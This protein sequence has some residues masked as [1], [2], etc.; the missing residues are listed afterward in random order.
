MS[1]TA[2]MSSLRIQSFEHPQ[3]CRVWL[4]VDE[5]TRDAL[6]LDPH[7]DLIA[8][9]GDTVERDRL[10]LR[11]IVDSHTHAD[12]PSGAAALQDRIGGTRVAHK[13]G[14][15]EGVE[16]HPDDGDNLELGTQVVQ[17]RHAPGHTPD[18]LVLL[19]DGHLFAG[20]TL[21]IGGV[22][23]A[24]FL[25]GD[26]G[27]LFDTLRRII[28]PLPGSTV[29][30]PGHDY[31]NRA[32]STLEVERQSNP[33][34]RMTDRAEFIKHLTANPPPIPA[35]MDLLLKWNREG[36]EFPRDVPPPEFAKFVNEGGASSVID[37]RTG[38][39]WR[40]SHIDGSEHIPMGQLAESVERIRQIPAPRML[41]C[42]SDQRARSAQNQLEELGVRGLVVAT[43][44]I[45]AFEAGGGTATKSRDVMSLERQVRLFAGTLVV[46]GVAFGVLVHPWFLAISAFAGCGLIFAGLTDHCGA[47]LLLAKMPWN[48]GGGNSAMREPVAACAASAPP[49]ACAA[50][51]PPASC[52]ASAP[53]SDSS[54]TR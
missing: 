12:H 6:I 8:S 50:S 1:A 33:W 24:D 29:L 40:M 45:L 43:G 31:Q 48:R 53:E 41:L 7:L 10:H 15:H 30:H 9:I 38:L 44:G 20:D 14:G 16:L 22:A 5:A 49:A 23:R 37:V 35:N 18:H 51:A 36:V 26:A 27:E 54:G 42:R 25:G 34:L 46:L 39:E 4:L 13:V 47:A 52:A 19:T 17:V 32:T 3:G 11:Y 28:D 2:P 21:L